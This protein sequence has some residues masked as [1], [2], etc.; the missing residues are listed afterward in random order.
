MNENEILLHFWIQAV[1]TG[2]VMLDFVP[3]PYREEIRKMEEEKGKS[4]E[5]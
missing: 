3:H 2:R 1:Q 5:D 4:K